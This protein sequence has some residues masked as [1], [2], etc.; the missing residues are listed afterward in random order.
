MFR[1]SFIA[2]FKGKK[3]FKRV[4][5]SKKSHDKIKENLKY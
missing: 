1:L 4:L 5:D 3:P 2:T